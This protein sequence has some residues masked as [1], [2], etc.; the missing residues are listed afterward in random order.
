MNE[1]NSLKDIE[2]EESCKLDEKVDEVETV[3][4]AQP[5]NEEQINVVEVESDVVKNY[6]IKNTK[7]NTTSFEQPQKTIST[8]TT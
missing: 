7:E 2:N 6:F 5:E 3:T 8:T 4:S 1:L